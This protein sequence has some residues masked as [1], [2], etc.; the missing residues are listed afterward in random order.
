MTTTIQVIKSLIVLTTVTVVEKSTKFNEHYNYLIHNIE[1]KEKEE[2]KEKK[3]LKMK[4]D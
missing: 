2:E 4:I 3:K 1:K